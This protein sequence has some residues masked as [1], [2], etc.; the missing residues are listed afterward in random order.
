MLK[1]HF[2]LVK[3]RTASISWDFFEV[4]K[5]FQKKLENKF[6]ASTRF[7]FFSMEVK[8]IHLTSVNTDGRKTPLKSATHSEGPHGMQSDERDFTLIHQTFTDARLYFPSPFTRLF[9]QRREGVCLFERDVPYLQGHPVYLISISNACQSTC[10]QTYQTWN[11]PAVNHADWTP[12]HVTVLLNKYVVIVCSLQS[13]K[14]SHHAS[15]AAPVWLLRVNFIYMLNGR[16]S[17]HTK[18][19][20]RL[21]FH[22]I[23]EEPAKY[24]KFWG[25]IIK[26]YLVAKFTRAT[27]FSFAL[28]IFLLRVRWQDRYH[29]DVCLL[30]MRLRPAA[31]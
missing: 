26:T 22:F 24:Y 18:Q 16:D 9:S 29:S 15:Q 7:L 20:I 23:S 25:F 13:I 12:T 3:I 1:L 4:Y 27:R 11:T 19:V 31:G 2:G 6:Q 28:L 21:K 17:Y 5:C 14:T 10:A 30:N 8:F